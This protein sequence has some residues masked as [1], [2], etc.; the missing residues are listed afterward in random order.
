MDVSDVLWGNLEPMCTLRRFERTLHYINTGHSWCWRA[1]H[2]GGFNTE[3]KMIHIHYILLEHER[4]A[5]A[6][7]EASL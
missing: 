3:L 4:S 2:S 6:V 7:N 5:G 1:K